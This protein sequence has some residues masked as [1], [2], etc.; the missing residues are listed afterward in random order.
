MLIIH[1][2]VKKMIVEQAKKQVKKSA[3]GDYNYGP[4]DYLHKELVQ[5]AALDELTERICLFHKIVHKVTD[6]KTFF[7][8]NFIRYD[9]L[10][11]C[12]Q[13]VWEVQQAFPGV[14]TETIVN[15]IRENAES[16][17]TEI[18]HGCK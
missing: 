15:W 10:I 4:I 14:K 5:S 12:R 18:W 16:N 3:S 11:D 17:Q 13:L 8:W 7:L 9:L 1:S 2:I 6:A